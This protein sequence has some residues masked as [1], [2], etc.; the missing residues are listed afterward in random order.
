M[1]CAYLAQS[2]NAPLKRNAR[3]DADCAEITLNLNDYND[4]L[5]PKTKKESPI[6]TEELPRVELMIAN[7]KSWMNS[8]GKEI[9]R[10]HD[11][12]K[13][14]HLLVIHD[15]LEKPVGKFTF[16]NGGSPN[17]HNGLKSIIQHLKRSVFFL[18]DS[19]IHTWAGF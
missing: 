1:F 2:F 5:T 4:I 16:K 10:I 17:G 14:S 18:S 13:P 19:F 3:G 15:E 12:Y 11:R 7:P 6:H 9:S 8:C